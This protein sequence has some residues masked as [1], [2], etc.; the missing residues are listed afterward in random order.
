MLPVHAS[1]L[2]MPGGNNLMNDSDD[3]S[4]AA[5]TFIVHGTFAK[6][7]SWWRLGNEFDQT[8]ADEL[9]VALSSKGISETVWKPALDSGFTYDDFSWSGANRHRDRVTGAKDIAANLERLGEQLGVSEASPLTVNFVAHSHG[10]NVV[11]EI[12]RRLPRNIQVG[13]VALLGTPLIS[14]RPTLRQLRLPIALI[15][16]FILLTTVSLAVVQLTNLAVTGQATEITRVVPTRAILLYAI[17]GTSIYGWFFFF[18]SSLL[19]WVWRILYSAWYP[20]RSLFR[21]SKRGVYGPS[22]REL[23]KVL[24]GRS[25]TLFTTKNDEADILLKLCSAPKTLYAEHVATHWNYLMRGL[26]FLFLRPLVYGIVFNLLEL[27]LERRALGF[28]WLAVRFF[29]YDVARPKALFGCKT[30]LMEEVYF[31]AQPLSAP[32]N[33]VTIED[34]TSRKKSSV[35]VEI[36]DRPRSVAVTLAEVIAE[37]KKQISLRHSFY[38]KNPA[39]VVRLGELLGS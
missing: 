25:I 13:R 7:E 11:L 27:S 17:L 16:L 2:A 30:D 39:L 10:G 19:T 24:N 5:F 23:A 3:L 22:E 38:Y 4:P 35:L 6:D 9:E 12:L 32:S 26:E 29:D 18:L 15:L 14:F 37:I 31:E 21:R 36:E 20:V 8:F 28:S 1:K 33:S 34:M